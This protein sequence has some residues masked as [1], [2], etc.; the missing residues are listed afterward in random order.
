MIRLY[1]TAHLRAK[2]VPYFEKKMDWITQEK[3]K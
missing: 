1:K 2:V 3:I